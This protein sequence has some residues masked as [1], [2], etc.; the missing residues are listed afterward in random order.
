MGLPDWIKNA[1]KTAKEYG[2]ALAGEHTIEFRI[3]QDASFAST[4]KENAK[5]YSVVVESSRRKTQLEKTKTE[6]NNCKTINNK[7]MQKIQKIKDLEEELVLLSR[8]YTKA[9]NLIDINNNIVASAATGF[10]DNVV[11]IPADC[12]VQI[13]LVCFPN[14]PYDAAALTRDIRVL[15]DVGAYDYT[16]MEVEVYRQETYLSGDWYL[17]GRKRVEEYGHGYYITLTDNYNKVKEESK[18]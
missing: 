13:R 8:K 11:S 4:L 16:Y 2:K 12:Q 5:K 6:C 7:L 18:D 10:N 3:R 17:V 15:K 1:G 14:Q 9:L